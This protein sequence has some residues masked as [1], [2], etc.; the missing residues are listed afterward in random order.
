MS[1]IRTVLG[2]ISSTELGVCYPHEHV[3]THPPANVVDP[4]LRMDS[5]AAA[6]QELTWFRQAGGQALVEM[7][8]PDYG[9]DAAGLCRVSAKTG[10]HIIC[11]TGYL[12]EQTCA[13]LVQN[14]SVD[15]LAERFIADLNQ[16]ID[17]TDI[18]AGVIKA[19][20]SLNRI[21]PNE[22]KV[23]RAAA[24]A[25][26][27]TGTPISTHTEAGTMGPEQIELLQAEGVEPKHIII[28]HTDRNLEWDYHLK[29]AQT[30]AYLGYDHISKEKYWPDSLRIEFILR[31]VAEGH[32]QQILLAGD[33]ARRSYWPSYGTGGGP[34]LTYI[35]WRFVPWL[36]AK[37]LAEEIIQD[38]LVHN[39][40]RALAI[41]LS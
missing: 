29:L 35:L 38:L 1:V 2:D 10:I 14:A 15:E 25:H 7:S 6:I 20:S 18:R 17:Q 19:G 11:A 26:H 4:D 24:R 16:G 39:P 9:R 22:E 8:T 32:G 33:L 5:E 21:T 36:R 30:G 27:T 37:G 23:F 41:S 12:K 13:P 3:L 28:G 40:A 34:G 31:L